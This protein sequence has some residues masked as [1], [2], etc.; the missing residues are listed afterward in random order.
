LIKKL[1]ADYL[2]ALQAV[3]DRADARE[4]SFYGCLEGM[5]QDYAA[6]KGLPR[7]AITTLP[8]ATS[9]NSSSKKHIYFLTDMPKWNA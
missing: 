3:I 1:L 7:C 8:K 9:H 6:Q 2:K 5:L 4:E